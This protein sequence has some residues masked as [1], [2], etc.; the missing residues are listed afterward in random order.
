VIDADN[1][2]VP[3]KPPRLD[4]LTLD[5]P[6]VPRGIVKAVGLAEIEKSA[7]APVVNVAPCAV[8]GSGVGVPLARVM[9][10]PG[11]LVGA[12]QP[13]WYP[14]GVPPVDAVTL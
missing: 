11:T 9:H 3:T 2:T 12:G 7:T 10:V 8:S 5:V 13:V 4:R 1:E 14:K 6:C